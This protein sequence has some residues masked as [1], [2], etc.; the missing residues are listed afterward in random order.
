MP[1]E[2]RA[3]GLGMALAGV[4]NRGL[5]MSLITPVKVEKLQ[6]ALIL[7]HNSG[8]GVK[9]PAQTASVFDTR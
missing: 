5:T 7:P 8:H 6:K 3:L 9:L 4:R 2:E 1:M